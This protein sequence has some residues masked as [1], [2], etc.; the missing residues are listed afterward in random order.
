MV[1]E[2]NGAETPSEEQC[3]CLASVSCQTEE[4][5]NK[6]V[7]DKLRKRID[8]LEQDLRETKNKL[9]LQK[10]PVNGPHLKQDGKILTFDTKNKVQKF[11]ASLSEQLKKNIGR[12][13]QADEQ[14]K[15]YVEKEQ[16]DYDQRL[17]ELK[18]K[19]EEE[20]SRAVEELKAALLIKHDSE[21]AEL[22]ETARLERERLEEDLKNRFEEEKRHAVETGRIG[23]QR[24]YEDELKRTRETSMLERERVVAE[25]KRERDLVLREAVRETK[26]KQ[27]CCNCEQEAFY[28]CCW[29][30]SYCSRQCQVIHWQQHRLHC[31]RNFVYLSRPTRN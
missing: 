18:K 23:M 13:D 12:A 11:I 6:A 2:V 5:P 8:D 22:R 1:G 30:T 19:A 15:K 29:N 20:K 28:P 17:D 9:N 16:S 4:D 25:M 14:I 21:I 7:I 3:K 27:W 26:R 10:M 24:K 31:N